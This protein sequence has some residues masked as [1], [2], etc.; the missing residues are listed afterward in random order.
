MNNNWKPLVILIILVAAVF[1]AAL[2]ATR[3]PPIH[4]PRFRQMQYR[5]PPGDIELFYTLK[6]VISTINATLLASLFVIYADIY[7]KVRS[8]FT[9]G[10]MI[11]TV[12]LLLY[13][14]S[15]NPMVHR[16][17]GFTA[18]GLGPFAMLPDLFTCAALIIL[19]YLA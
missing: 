10:L 13:A 6:T 1:L 2:W 15:S 11:F 4:Q 16:L 14:L 5:P 12:T 3:P 7:R 17:F 19:L 18:F 8:D 9:I